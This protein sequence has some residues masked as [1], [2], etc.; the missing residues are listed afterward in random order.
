MGNLY[1]DV[2]SRRLITGFGFRGFSLFCLPQ[3]FFLIG[4][5]LLLFG[6]IGLGIDFG[7]SYVSDSHYPIHLIYAIIISHPN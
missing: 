6:N 1:L 7:Y 4:A 2:Y 5:L 3:A